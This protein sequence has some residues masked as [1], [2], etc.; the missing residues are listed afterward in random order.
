MIRQCIEGM[1]ARGSVLSRYEKYDWRALAVVALGAAALNL[2]LSQL[3]LTL[4]SGHKLTFAAVPLVLLAALCGTMP[5]LLTVPVMALGYGIE[6]TWWMHI[7]GAALVGAL[8]RTRLPIAVTMLA[9]VAAELLPFPTVAP[10][11]PGFDQWCAQILSSLVSFNLAVSLWMLLPRRSP[12]TRQHQR[13][14]LAQRIFVWSMTGALLPMLIAAV[15]PLAS[16]SYDAAR[17]ANAAD[18]YVVLL[19]AVV[20]AAVCAWL[21][22]IVSTSTRVLAPLAPAEAGNPA[23]V[24]SRSWLGQSPPEFAGAVLSWRRQ[25]ARMQ[26]MLRRAHDQLMQERGKNERLR[27]SSAKLLQRLKEQSQTLLEAQ[28]R[29]IVNVKGLENA[30]QQ[31]YATIQQIRTSRTLFI[32]MMSHEVRTPLHGLMSTLSLLRDEQLS[33]EGVRRLGIARTSARSLLQI[34]NDILDLS[35][36]EAGG[37]SLEKAPFDPRR[38]VREIAEEFLASAQAQRL[39]L[40]AAIADDVPAVLVGDRTRIRQIASNLVTNA[41]KFTPTGRITIHVSWCSGKLVIDVIDTGKGVPPDK[42]EL[43]FDSFIQAESSP[44]RRFS[45]TGLGL[46]IGRHL[47]HAMGG[48]LALH[49]TGSSGSTFRL[50]LTLEISTEQV[51]EEESQRVLAHYAGHVLVVEDNEANQYVVKV[52][53]ESLGCTVSIAASGARALALAEEAK[54]DMVLMDCQLPGMD[55]FETCRRMRRTMTSRV[56]II[57]MTANALAEDKTRC[58]EAGMDDFL[59]KPFSKAALSRVLGHWFAVQGE[60]AAD[61]EARASESEPVLDPVVFEELWES[62]RWRTKPLEEIYEAVVVNVRNT[63]QL[64][65]GLG[66]TPTQKILRSLHTIRGSASMVGAKRIARIAG[67]LEHAASNEQLTRETV[68]H[69]QL[70]KALRELELA[71]RERLSSYDSRS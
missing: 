49:A 26:R 1:L 8:L 7:P 42:R 54:F 50:E 44:N 40:A 63:I 30:L 4:P 43:I 24:R 57:A 71:V 10:E 68:E 5:V 28:R 47:A 14:S 66:S 11:L 13:R 27:A 61:V 37:F 55:G 53:L 41:L 60:S 16:R 39:E 46:T 23:L 21:S 29:D 6:P 48:S 58:L 38:L 45:G 17:S 25:L 62:L 31:A 18:I 35:S 67:I 70:P 56:P 2:T 20:A 52:L 12:V 59:P 15:A 64:L 33:A 51:T 22:Q 36:I 32:G 3:P 69:A 65:A 19:G 9:Y 34:A